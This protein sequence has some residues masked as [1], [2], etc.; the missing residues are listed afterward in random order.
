MNAIVMPWVC[1]P[2]LLLSLGIRDKTCQSSPV[3]VEN[4]LIAI[5]NL[6]CSS[7]SKGLWIESV[8]VLSRLFTPVLKK[9]LSLRN[10]QGVF[11]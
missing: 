11:L 4:P 9:K 6:E 2:V 1:C 10:V 8:R 3:N 7:R 5:R